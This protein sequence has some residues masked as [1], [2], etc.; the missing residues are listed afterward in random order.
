MLSMVR[1]MHSALLFC[2]EVYGHERRKAMPRLDR[3]DVDV[4]GSVDELCVIISL[5]AFRQ[6]VELSV[7]I[8]SKI[9]N[10]VVH[11]RFVS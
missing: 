1:N 7:S 3:K 10:M 4:V 6:G 9:D 11:V 8:D 2:G 5:K